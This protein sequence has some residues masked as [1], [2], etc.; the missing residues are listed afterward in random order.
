MKILFN[1]N[2]NLPSVVIT[3]PEQ[4]MI[5]IQSSKMKTSW[6]NQ[7]NLVFAVLELSRLHIY[8]SYYDKM[9]PNFGDGLVNMDE[10]ISLRSKMHAIKC[11]IDSKNKEE[12]FANINRKLLVLSYIKN[13]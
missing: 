13:V 8:E 5:V 12:V 1:Y 6:V 11:G 9:Q 2:Q 3:N 10:L 4:I 7:K